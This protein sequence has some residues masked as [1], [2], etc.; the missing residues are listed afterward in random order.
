MQTL[1]GKRH[2]LCYG[3]QT[4]NNLWN[5][6]VEYFRLFRYGYL[7]PLSELNMG[8]TSSNDASSPREPNLRD[9][10]W[11]L[12]SAMSPGV[13][14]GE[15]SGVDAL[16][17]QWRRYSTYFGHLIFQLK[18]RRSSLMGLWLHLPR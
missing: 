10:E 5:V 6:A 7:A 12:R 13:T 1:S 18:K 3:V 2:T 14:I 8:A 9:K 16:I 4:K 11:F 17:E 15:L